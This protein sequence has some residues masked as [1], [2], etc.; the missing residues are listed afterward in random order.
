VTSV[1][2]HAAGPPQNESEF[3]TEVPKAQRIHV[4]LMKILAGDAIILFFV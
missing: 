1:T 4:M 3:R 2:A